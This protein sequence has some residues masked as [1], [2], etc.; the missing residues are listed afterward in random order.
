MDDSER[1]L[2]PLQM[3]HD[4]VELLVRALGYQDKPHLLYSHISA[5]GERYLDDLADRR[6]LRQIMDVEFLR[7][8]SRL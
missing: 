2:D 1:A 6:L 4:V 3:K 8:R 5:M 7:S